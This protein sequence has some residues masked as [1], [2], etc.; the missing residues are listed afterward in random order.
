MKP[1]LRIVVFAAAVAAALAGAVAVRA[2]QPVPLP[3]F[4]IAQLDGTPVQSQ[5]GLPSSGKWLIVYVRPNCAPCDR[6]LNLIKKDAHPGLPSKMVVIA[7][8]LDGLAATEARARFK[9]LAD[10]QWYTD[11]P[12][13]AW[14]A[15]KVFGVPMVFGVRDRTI[16]WSLSGVLP[17]DAQVKSILAS[18]AAE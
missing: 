14:V 11:R 1:R 15:L 17:S 16:E 9:E 8:G 2:S 10:A 3:E 4:E 13:K 7:G 5:S 6:L 18:W 12:G